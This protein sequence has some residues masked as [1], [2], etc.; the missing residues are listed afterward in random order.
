MSASSDALARLKI[1]PLLDELRAC[2]CTKVGTEGLCFCGILLGEDIPLEYAGAA[3]PTKANQLGAAGQP[4]T[5]SFLRGDSIEEQRD[6]AA[7]DHAN[8]LKA[9]EALQKV[10][11]HGGKID[12]D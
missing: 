8:E 5:G 12:V 9:L 11:D 1:Y 6:N 2:L 3:V 4:G 10:Q 7:R